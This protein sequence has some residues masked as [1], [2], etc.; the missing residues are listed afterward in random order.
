MGLTAF[1]SCQGTLCTRRSDYASTTSTETR[2]L[3]AVMHMVAGMLGASDMRSTKSGVTC[4]GP[5]AGSWSLHPCETNPST[6]TNRSGGSG[7]R[8]GNGGGRNT[9]GAWELVVELNSLP[10]L[11]PPPPPAPLPYYLPPATHTLSSPRRDLGTPASSDYENGPNIRSGLPIASRSLPQSPS[12]PTMLACDR[13]YPPRKSPGVGPQPGPP[14][15]AGDLKIQIFRGTITDPRHDVFTGPA[16]QF[17]VWL[18]TSFLDA[19]V[20]RLELH[21]TELDKLSK[22]LRRWR[23]D[24]SIVLEYEALS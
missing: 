21:R 13:D 23:G 4:T 3:S 2:G 6:D 8:L 16:T 17:S 14:V 24:V 5:D 10:P 19:R 1:S 7:G 22:P 20:G 15:L 12:S 18:S 11:P 9:T